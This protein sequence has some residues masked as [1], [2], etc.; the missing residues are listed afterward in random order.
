MPFGF[1][2]QNNLQIYG[3]GKGNIII[4]EWTDDDCSDLLGRVK[5]SLDRFEQ[6]CDVHRGDLQ[7]EAYGIDV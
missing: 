3:D 4:E 1:E 5:I 2:M 6:I 7:K